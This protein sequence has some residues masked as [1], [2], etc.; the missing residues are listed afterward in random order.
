MPMDEI[1]SSHR[2]SSLLE[3]LLS[4]GHKS[5]TIT[6]YVMKLQ[7]INRGCEN[8]CFLQLF[9]ITQHIQLKH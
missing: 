5:F 9:Y 6:E 8:V 3:F 4:K 7:R 2:G 1:T